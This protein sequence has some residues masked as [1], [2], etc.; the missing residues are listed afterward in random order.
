MKLS[1]LSLAV[2]VALGVAACG[3][4]DDNNNAP[5]DPPP[6]G[7]NNNGG[8]TPPPP[9]DNS[10]KPQDPARVAPGNEVQDA[11]KQH[12]VAAKTTY[13]SAG[14][15]D[16]LTGY[17]PG[18]GI[19]AVGNDPRVN[20]A[21]VYFRNSTKEHDVKRVSSRINYVATGQ[22]RTN[23]Q[24]SDRNGTVLANPGFTYAL[25]SDGN[26]HRMVPANNQNWDET[27]LD[28]RYVPV[29][30]AHNDK[31]P[32]GRVRQD[33]LFFLP[34]VEAQVG[35]PEQA[36]GLLVGNER[37]INLVDPEVNSGNFDTNRG[38][39]IFKTAEFN[40]K[41]Y[42]ISTAKAI[43]KVDLNSIAIDKNAVQYLPVKLNYDVKDT[44]GTDRKSVV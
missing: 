9:A 4:S 26:W 41:S 35:A 20:D 32:G 14:T 3:G 11:V 23:A 40:G 8:N 19:V 38:E 18:V 21:T 2:L 10:Q 1:N 33:A 39:V 25:G 36:G 6:P 5:Q 24:V 37:G 13:A 22:L 34:N 29:D 12:V 15:R 28:T 16:L 31:F 30:T 7:D 43:D 27:T 44:K 17:A 42:D